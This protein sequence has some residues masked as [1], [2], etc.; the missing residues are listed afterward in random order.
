MMQMHADEKIIKAFEVKKSTHGGGVFYITN[1]GVYFESLRYGMV[2]ETGFELLRSYNAVKKNVFQIVWSAQNNERFSYEIKV[3]SAEEVM[4]VCK[5][6][7]TEYA[8]SM[9][10]IQ[11]L[12][13]E[14]T[15]T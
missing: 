4:T 7:N 9:T 2:V 10:E 6:A 12:K 5:D 8:R 14:H 3:G 11:V 15:V 1:L 13:S